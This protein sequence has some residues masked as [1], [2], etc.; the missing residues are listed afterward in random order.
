MKTQITQDSRVKDVMDNFE[1]LHGKAKAQQLDALVFLSM[2]VL[3]VR[4]SALHVAK[5]DPVTAAL[6]AL[7]VSAMMNTIVDLC[8]QLGIDKLSLLA[9]INGLC[10]DI[11][12]RR[13]DVDQKQG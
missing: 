12:D 1:H 8:Q 13:A 6:L 7:N 3:S 9:A 10:K 11:G 4:V 5:D 2:N